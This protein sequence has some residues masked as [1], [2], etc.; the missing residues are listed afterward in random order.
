[1]DKKPWPRPHESGAA[2]L[3][4]GEEQ[5]LRKQGE[6]IFFSDTGAPGPAPCGIAAAAEVREH[7]AA[8]R[9]GIG[10]LLCPLKGDFGGSPLLWQV[11]PEGP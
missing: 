7:H 1:M 9:P 4:G 11:W 3:E 2:N 5:Q 6:N 10:E 8:P